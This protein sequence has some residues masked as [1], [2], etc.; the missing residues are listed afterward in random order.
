MPVWVP[1]LLLFGGLIIGLQ[2]LQDDAR[3]RG[4]AKIDVTRYRLMADSQWLSAAW[5]DELERI[6]VQVR[7]LPVDDTEQIQAF[8]DEIAALP[9][10]DR[11]GAFSVQWPDGLIIPIKM[12]EPVACIRTGDRDFLPVAADGTVLGGYTY[13]PH[14]AYGGWLPT[15]GPHGFVEERQGLLEPGS[16]IEV[17]E[18]LA[19]LSVANSM[20]M[21]LGVED[22]LRI[23]RIVIDATA[24]DAPVL[25]RAATALKPAR[26]PGGVKIDLEGGRRI[27]FGR[28]P[29]PVHSGELPVG[30]KWSHVRSA[31]EATESAEGNWALLDVRFDESVRLTRSEIEEIVA[32][33]QAAPSEGR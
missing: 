31:M 30:Y 1:L 5:T 21:H 9:F 18:A 22:L 11:V 6:L 2:A 14:A 26:L 10:V 33:S 24:T 16:K 13:A 29:F 19:A 28:P 3:Q 8:S 27:F 17:P 25:D 12:H 15:L 20:W 4:V 7:T 32:R 23:G